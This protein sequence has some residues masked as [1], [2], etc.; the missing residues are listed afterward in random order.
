MTL[1]IR[2]ARLC[3]DAEGCF[4]SLSYVF[5]SVFLY[6]LFHFY[7]FRIQTRRRRFLSIHREAPSK[8]RIFVL[9]ASS[10]IEF[11]S[12]RP[13]KCTNT[14]N[15]S[16]RN[17]RRVS[18]DSSPIIQ[19]KKTENRGGGHCRGFSQL[20]FGLMEE[21]GRALL[22]EMRTFVVVFAFVPTFIEADDGARW[23]AA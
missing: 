5:S 7:S 8:E 2:C 13:F 3:E 12:F 18:E 6:P 22:A 19:F 14:A 4:E 15:D 11:I 23:M 16:A 9:I 17:R 1:H 10:E 21:G 20:N